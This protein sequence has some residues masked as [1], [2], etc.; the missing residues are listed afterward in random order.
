ME[1]GTDI[2]HGQWSQYE[3]SLSS[4]WREV[5]AVSFVFQSFAPKL[6]GHR[7]KWFT[8]KAT[9]SCTSVSGALGRTS[10][11]NFYMGTQN[12]SKLES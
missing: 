7:V 10:G 9:A 12:G 1:V 4:T 11:N 2:A 5:K 6:A 3:A 8:D